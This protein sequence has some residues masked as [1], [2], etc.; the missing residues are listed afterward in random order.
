MRDVAIIGVGIN[1][2]GELW[3]GSLRDIAVESALKAIKDAK[4]DR[5]DSV[6]IG[7]MSSGLFTGQEHLASVL[8]DYLGL[9]PVP[10]TRVESACASG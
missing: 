7:C 2:W 5:V 6:F 4:V 9:C 3:A 10:V 1:K 8:A